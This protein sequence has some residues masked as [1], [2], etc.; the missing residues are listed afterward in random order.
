VEAW[1]SGV[2]V[3]GLR[4]FDGFDGLGSF[5]SWLWFRRFSP[6][7]NAL[8]TGPIGLFV[9]EDSIATYER[10]IY[11]CVSESCASC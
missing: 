11:S 7:V 6:T 5:C 1:G 3:A 8:I 10:M 9:S 2:R 4:S